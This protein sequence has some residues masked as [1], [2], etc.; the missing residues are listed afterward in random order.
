MVDQRLHGNRKKSETQANGS[1]KK[2]LLFFVT[3]CIA[4]A[5][6]QKHQ[7]PRLRHVWG[8]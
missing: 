5:V 2:E 4:V 7:Q 3:A 1:T 8:E 6:L